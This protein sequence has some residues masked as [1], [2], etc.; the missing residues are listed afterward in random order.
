MD[1]S[2][3]KTKNLKQK[4]I[5][6]ESSSSLSSSDFSLEKEEV[7]IKL[8]QQTSNLIKM[9]KKQKSTI[10]KNKIVNQ[11]LLGKIKDLD[12]KNKD[13]SN[14]QSYIFNS[15]SIPNNLT[16]EE[17][18]NKVELFKN[19]NNLLVLLQNEFN[20]QSIDDIVNEIHRI[21]AIKNDYGSIITSL[22][23]TL[24]INNS[25]S[26]SPIDQII[27][28]IQQLKQKKLELQAKEMEICLLL[29]VSEADENQRSLKV[30]E[31]IKA[32]I[33]QHNNEFL[34]CTEML[35]IDSKTAISNLKKQLQDSQLEIQ[36]KK[37][38]L[39]K[40][41]KI[42]VT[43]AQIARKYNCSSIEQMGEVLQDLMELT[44][45]VTAENLSNI[46][47]QMQD[48][49]TSLRDQNA[50]LQSQNRL[51]SINN[52]TINEQ[53]TKT[54][55]LLREA[56]H[57]YNEAEAKR[58]ALKSNMK[59]LRSK[60]I[61][62]NGELNAK[63]IENNSLSSQIENKNEEIISLKG[64][65]QNQSGNIS[66]QFDEMQE[67]VLSIKTELRKVQQENE[68]VRSRLTSV[69]M[70]RDL[71]KHERDSLATEKMDQE[72]QIENLHQKVQQLSNEIQNKNDELNGITT[73]LE[74]NE[75]NNILF[76][77]QKEEIAF[78]EEET[79]TKIK[80]LQ[81]QILN[82]QNQ[83][84][85]LESE[86]S[87]L[88]CE[89]EFYINENKSLMINKATGSSNTEKNS[90]DESDLKLQISDLSYRLEKA[91]KD[92]KALQMENINL[93]NEI[94]Q[95]K[96]KKDK[97]NQNIT[98]SK[99]TYTQS[100]DVYMS[101]LNHIKHDQDM[102]IDLKP[103]D[104]DQSQNDSL[105]NTKNI[106]PIISSKNNKKISENSNDSH[107]IQTSNQ[108]LHTKIDEENKKKELI[109]D[110]TNLLYLD[111]EKLKEKNS[112][113]KKIIEQLKNDISLLKTQTPLQTTLKSE[114]IEQNELLKN[115]TR[116]NEKLKADNKKIQL[117]LALLRNECDA[118]KEMAE[119]QKQ[120]KKLNKEENQSLQKLKLE[121][122]RK[123][124]NEKAQ[125]ELSNNRIHEIDEINKNINSKLEE[126]LNQNKLLNNENEFIN[127][128]LSDQQQK[129][130]KI[131]IL[132][133]NLSKS[134][135]FNNY[136]VKFTKFL[137]KIENML[138]FKDQNENIIS[139]IT[140]DNDERND[141][142]SL[143][144]HNTNEI[145]NNIQYLK[146]NLL[147]LASMLNIKLPNENFFDDSQIIS[148]FDEIKSSIAKINKRMPKHD[149][150]EANQLLNNTLDDSSY[151]L[152]KSTIINRI[153]QLLKVS[154]NE[155]VEFIEK[156][157]NDIVS[158]CDTIGI[159]YNNWK[160][161]VIERINARKQESN[162]SQLNKYIA[163]LQTFYGL[164]YHENS[165]NS[166]T[167][168]A[169]KL[170]LLIT[171]RITDLIRN[172]ESSQDMLHKTNAS[173]ELIAE[174]KNH[175][176]KLNQQNEDIQV[177]YTNIN[178]K[179]FE[180]EADYTKLQL[181]FDIIQQ[182]N[183]SFQ[184]KLE[185]SLD[186][187]N[188]LNSI[189]KILQISPTN[190]IHEN[191]YQEILNKMHK[192]QNEKEFFS[193]IKYLLSSIFN[194][195]N[196]MDLYDDN[197]ASTILE[198][199]D[200]LF[201]DIIQLCSLYNVK[202]PFR[203]FEIIQYQYKSLYSLLRVYRINENGNNV[204]EELFTESKNSKL[205]LDSIQ[206]MFPSSTIDP[207][208]SFN[209]N[210]KNNSIVNAIKDIKS[211]LNQIKSKNEY[212]NQL[213]NQ[214]NQFMEIEDKDDY[215]S[216]QLAIK[217]MQSKIN[218]SQRII[219]RISSLL[220]CE[221]EYIYE[222]VN[223]LY[224]AFLHLAQL[225][226]ISDTGTSAL[227][228][229]IE[230]T[231]SSLKSQYD[232]MIKEKNDE[233]NFIRTCLKELSIDEHSPEESIRYS[234]TKLKNVNKTLKDENESLKKSQDET[235]LQIVTL[236]E[237]NKQLLTQKCQLYNA[238]NIEDNGSNYRDV[239][240]RIY[241]LIDIE[242][243]YQKISS[244]LHS[245][246]DIISKYEQENIKY[247]NQ[248]KQTRY[249]ITN[250]NEAY[251]QMSAHEFQI[252]R[253][254]EI[255]NLPSSPF[256]IVVD[257]VEKIL[258]ELK[259]TKENNEK[260]LADFT[261]SNKRIRDFDKA[262][263]QFQELIQNQEVKIEEL[264]DSLDQR[265][266]QLNFL[267]SS[268]QK[269]F[270]SLGSV[271]SI[272]LAIDS[273]KELQ[274]RNED[275]E[276]ELGDIRT[277]NAVN[278][279]MKII[280]DNEDEKIKLI[281]KSI[282]EQYDNFNTTISE[283][284]QKVDKKNQSTAEIKRILNDVEEDNYRLLELLDPPLVPPNNSR[285]NSITCN[286]LDQKLQPHIYPTIAGLND[287][288]VLSSAS[289]NSQGRSRIHIG[290][291]LALNPFDKQ[292]VDILNADYN[293]PRHPSYASNDIN[294][295]IQSAELQIT[296][297]TRQIHKAYITGHR[298]STNL[299]QT[300]LL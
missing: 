256:P 82:L 77:K 170:I 140:N 49:I 142:D 289:L 180:L 73:K 270:D 240:D 4:K 76:N 290:S 196:N 104:I 235:D 52:E 214:L 94:A 216:V 41:Q 75:N 156:Q 100:S 143:I 107:Q 215:K 10:E 298:L 124:E 57:Q 28:N 281:K 238:I 48:I 93:I 239:I 64:L 224:Q 163:S 175:I 8:K 246:S 92:Y 217:N 68:I 269:I 160:S 260:I 191:T 167:I 3:K 126:L 88:K 70:E 38:R 132:I 22:L 27:S 300:T 139:D 162:E 63:I 236:D 174:L 141:L 91:H 257:K 26:L 110:N 81:N 150:D 164:L 108:N 221:S 193:K 178:S 6:N 272:Q 185:N 190:P 149:Y 121:L 209:N 24:E 80:Q 83:I 29:N 251:K 69:E 71:L 151:E 220:N 79:K 284:Q 78:N 275:L 84:D 37:K 59:S 200:R 17:L 189:Y 35:S 15:L 201:K 229:S 46:V 115:Q 202:D 5:I 125:L 266:I 176:K 271:N 32:L 169:D 183:N 286:Q 255:L 165:E 145:S 61:S 152:N 199:I 43:Y 98:L 198:K 276:Q 65:L 277:S 128:K 117:E 36:D 155:I 127:E 161:E 45:A 206:T 144:P 295:K 259:Q 194:D 136:D 242:N 249:Q 287:I 211:Q 33:K 30:L 168:D 134:S 248:I 40:L 225:L 62:I 210:Q 261:A 89:N 112:E 205:V 87:K 72:D 258:N 16:K 283:I 274:K 102:I 58:L 294:S 204:W 131:L 133:E 227:V 158:L 111:I 197:E 34:E 74:A 135:D 245:D 223:S 114:S 279:A 120:K 119:K 90:N 267:E 213:N 31:S 148:L 153:K 299:L 85:N 106:S 172:I 280:S 2:R 288:N 14:F 86:N 7:F 122:E 292:G 282:K 244:K 146:E 44:G 177:Q 95:L 116:E 123:L 137:Q 159:D 50:S 55:N 154:D 182:Q 23:K 250:I 263:T 166:H 173:H 19:G 56:K 273:I 192:L 12:N 171:Q 53:L 226:N 13:L 130:Q 296:R 97:D 252:E 157:N 207:K 265:D 231:I 218:F 51:A 186:M 138:Q 268:L 222:N 219:A 47:H 232:I 20:M 233:N 297:H 11:K 96:H 9:N 129:I 241:N 147:N 21:K 184:L 237:Q 179:Y 278:D 118:N 264:T 230:K 291:A 253:L 60:L 203:L 208:E 293:S 66:F 254:R 25:S 228:S 195:K 101:E 42:D 103:H 18:Q 54:Q 187:E 67:K 99:E 247:I 262:E 113:K 285:T 234:I 105:N 39:E 212:E 188:C 109:N 181:Q 243:K 1:E